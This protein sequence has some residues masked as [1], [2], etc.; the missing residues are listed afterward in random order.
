MSMHLYNQ[1]QGNLLGLFPPQIPDLLKSLSFPFNRAIVFALILLLGTASALGQRSDPYDAA[2]RL[3]KLSLEELMEIEV[4][5]VSRGPEKLIEVA[6]PVQVI[7]NQDIHRSSAT[8][9]PE[10]LRLAPNLMA[11]QL[12]SHD[13]AIS[14]RGFNGAPLTNNSISPN[15]FKSSGL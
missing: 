5:S 11:A 6:S 14:S 8:R 10:A 12:N 4:T 3:K 13:W 7:T 1:A 9:L 2:E 15:F